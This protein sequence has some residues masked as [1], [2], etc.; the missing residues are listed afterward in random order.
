[1]VFIHILLILAMG[2]IRVM[3]KVENK[4]DTLKNMRSPHGAKAAK[5]ISWIYVRVNLCNLI[6]F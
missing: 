5:N 3:H 6:E 4:Q 2:Q 1:M